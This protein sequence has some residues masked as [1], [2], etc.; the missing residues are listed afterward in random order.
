MILD[1][2]LLDKI[3]YLS[4]RLDERKLDI[5]VGLA[6]DNLVQEAAMY[7][8][9]QDVDNELRKDEVTKAYAEAWDFARSS[10]H[11]Q[12]NFL[13]LGEVAGR[14]SPDLTKDNQ[15]YLEWRKGSV[16]LRGISYKPPIDESRIINQL[17]RLEQVIKDQP[18][19]HAE[20]A[21]LLNF[22]LT[23]I[24]PFDNGNKRTSSIM[25]NLMLR[26]NNLPPIY[27]TP[28]ERFTYISLLQSALE[29]FQ[30]RSCQ[31]TDPLE[32]FYIPDYQQRGYYD[33][34]GQ[35]IINNLVLAEDKLKQ[36]PLFEID[37][38]AKEVGVYFKVKKEIDGHLRHNGKP[39]QVR[40]F[41]NEKNRIQI[42]GE[43]S[44]QSLEQILRKN[45]G[46]TSFSIECKRINGDH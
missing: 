22:H 33:Y 43:V 44:L 12:F 14:V 23:R 17:E 7:A 34:L 36:Y 13:F 28:S 39:H 20:E 38:T 19:H 16:N 18:L 46:V 29:G 27:I 3:D 11:G 6:M 21:L 26:Y 8:P 45:K 35:K 37:L 24:Q 10:Y 9:I 25:M 40:L 5:L 2:A 1:K 32:A 30:E 41:R 31:V 4:Q 42:V 15:K